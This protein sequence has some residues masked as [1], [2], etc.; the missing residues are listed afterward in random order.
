MKL[1]Q[2]IRHVYGSFK[3]KRTGSLDS[4][5][6]DSKRI[7]FD[8][9]LR[10]GNK[11]ETR[12][13]ELRRRFNE[14]GKQEWSLYIIKYADYTSYDYFPLS[15]SFICQL[16]DETTKNLK[17]TLVLVENVL[18]LK[19]RNLSDKWRFVEFIR[20]N[21]ETK[22]HHFSGE[23]DASPLRT[24]PSHPIHVFFHHT[25]L[26]FI[27]QNSGRMLAHKSL[28]DMDLLIFKD[29][30]ISF[31]CKSP[32]ELWSIHMENSEKL[33][34][35]MSEAIEIRGLPVII[36]DVV[37]HKKRGEEPEYV[38]IPSSVYTDF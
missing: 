37:E 1:F 20:A 26:L 31:V 32:L 25:C 5:F 13:M 3:Q 12:S 33:S 27:S 17:C 30:K 22:A 36:N 14:S 7:K 28:F 2:S 9:K 11:Y 35:L 10:I 4:L 15:D 38:Q 23:I 24:F 19:M 16:F 29:Q 34:D 21:L 8:V 6:M 18:R